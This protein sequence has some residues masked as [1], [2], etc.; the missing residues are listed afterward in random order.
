M[1]IELSCSEGW[2]DYIPDE[3]EVLELELMLQVQKECPHLSFSEEDGC[4]DCGYDAK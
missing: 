4:L 2:E 1:E 3:T